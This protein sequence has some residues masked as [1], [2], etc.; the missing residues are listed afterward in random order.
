[1]S[2]VTNAA[3]LLVPAAMMGA[4][5]ALVFPSLLALASTQVAK[6]S[7][8]TGMGLVG[9]LRN[10]GKVAGPVGAGALIAWFDF[11]TSFRMISAVLGGG[12]AVGW[13]GLY[14]MRRRTAAGPSAHRAATGIVA[15]KVG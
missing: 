12:L 14:L 10:A 13:A 9:A 1:M 8:A 3:V 2:V 5:Q 15:S 6:D 7:I 4:S 11:E